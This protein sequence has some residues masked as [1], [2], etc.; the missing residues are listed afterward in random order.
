[1]NTVTLTVTDVHSN[2]NTCTATVT[3]VDN[4]APTV[5]CSNYSVDLSAGGTATI[6]PAMV[7]NG[8]NDACGI[9]SLVLDVTNFTCANVG[10]NSVT[11]TVTDNNS[12]A[13]TCTATVTVND[14][15]PPA[16]ICQNITVQLSAGGTATI[17]AAQVDDGSN[18]ACGIATLSVSP[19]SFG[20]ANVG[21]NS[22]T[23][24]VTDV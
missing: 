8:S 23:L 12:N 5:T 9:L 11:L 4:I 17:T 18:D 15:T 3:V 22:V 2:T 14:V 6:T 7:N 16:A 20:C 13:S 1:T 24:T 21:P 19:S 10:G